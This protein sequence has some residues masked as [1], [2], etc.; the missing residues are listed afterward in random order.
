LEE[1]VPLKET[2]LLDA[3]GPLDE[4]VPVADTD[5]AETTRRRMTAKQAAAVQRLVDAAADEARDN[6]YDGM[7]VRSA[8]RRAGVAPAT[9][10]TYFASKDHLLAEVLWRR[11][12]ALPPAVCPA[13]A[14]VLE[15]L[16]RAL[17]DLGLFMADD[18]QLA[19]ACTTA[20]LGS[21]P[22]VRALRV[23]FGGELHARLA[24]ALGDDADPTVALS[25]DL[26]YSGAMLW[27]GMGHLP[28]ASVPDALVE[29]AQALV[30]NDP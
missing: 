24:A 13:G 27:A 30:G 29:V 11:F 26:A 9:A 6:G 17:T 21:G 14:G 2:V 1:T 5:G 18:P 7:T 19:A 8:S 25:L 28:Y 16:T 4:A 10:Y 22:D 15:R 20:L 23:R 3:N 12:H